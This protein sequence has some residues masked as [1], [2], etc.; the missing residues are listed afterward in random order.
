MLYM[1]IETY[2]TATNIARDVINHQFDS[3]IPNLVLNE[4]GSLREHMALVTETLGR[5]CQETERLHKE[6]KSQLDPSTFAKIGNCSVPWEEEMQIL[7]E[8]HEKN[9]S[10]PGCGGAPLI[11]VKLAG[12][13]VMS[14]ALPSPAHLK[15]LIIYDVCIRDL[16]CDGQRVCKALTGDMSNCVP[17]THL[18]WE[19]VEVLWPRCE[20]YVDWVRHLRAYAEWEHESLW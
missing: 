11:A 13:C 9:G 20:Y 15:D 16:C 18:V 12:D 19:C 5:V 8:L 14:S 6:L 10:R 2:T 3:D 17:A 4:D 7:Q 1:F